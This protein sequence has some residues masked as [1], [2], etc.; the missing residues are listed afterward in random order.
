MLNLRHAWTHIRTLLPEM[1]RFVMLGLV[2]YGLGVAL[3]AMFREVLHFEEH[4]AVGCSL[5]ILFLIN[6]WLSR[7][8][9]FRAAKGHPGRQMALFLGT[10]MAMRIGEYYGFLLLSKVLGVQYLLALTIAMAISSAAKFFIYRIIVFG[11]VR[12]KSVGEA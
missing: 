8:I 7:N 3:S 11:R 5:V 12:D 10:S 1:Q 6:F 4:V 2:S 9:V